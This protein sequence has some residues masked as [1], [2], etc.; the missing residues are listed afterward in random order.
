MSRIFD[1]E[2]YE[3]VH[4]DDDMYDDDTYDHDTYDEHAHADDDLL[5][6]GPGGGLLPGEPEPADHQPPTRRQRPHHVRWGAL[7]SAVA[8]VAIGGYFALQALSGLIPSFNLGSDAPQDYPGPGTGEVTVEIPDGAGGAEIGQV[9]AAADVVASPEAFSSVAIGDDRSATIQPGTYTMAEQMSSAEA[10][11]RL[12]DPAY[13]VVSGVT[14]R[15][16]LWKEEVFA[17]L[18]EGT[19]NE[20]ADYEAVDS[21]D[22]E[23]P[24]AAGG[25]VE[26]YLFPDTYSFGP[27]STPEQHLK[28]MVDLG[29]Q[30]YEA[31]GLDGPELETTL[32]E[33]SLIQAEAAFSDDLPRVARVIENR[34]GDEMPLGFDSTIHYMFKE[35]GRAGTTDAQRETESPYN[36]YL[37]TGLP[38]APIN[39]PGVAAIEA[40][41]NPAE[42]PWVYFVTVDPSTGE[43]KFATT[44]KE[45]Q[46]NVAQFQQWCRDNPDEC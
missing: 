19:G 7:L 38:P 1:D 4:H 35:R 33:A 43:T 6:D 12:V 45:H 34:L 5:H 8:V 29:K 31:L 36:T 42:G 26:G 13:R 41:M 15:E 28:A 40:A 25:D 11:E 9:L 16:G 37:N 18:A 44:F 39:S 30:R 2:R 14:V 3:R 10:L 21:A 32:V 24:D 23:L 20:V 22:L 46:Q 27:D 17:L